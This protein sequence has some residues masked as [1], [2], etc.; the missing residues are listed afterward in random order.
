MAAVEYKL[1]S[2]EE[3]MRRARL[4]LLDAQPSTPTT[5]AAI[6]SDFGRWTPLANS[7]GFAFKSEY[8]LSDFLCYEDGEFIQFAYQ[9]ILL[10]EPD[11]QAQ[12]Y[13]LALRS[14]ELSKVE[15]V[16][17][18]RFSAEGMSHQVHI[19]GLL[20]PYK[21]QGW[22]R[23]P[24]IGG[25]I[26][27]A[28]SILRLPRLLLHKE[29]QIGRLAQRLQE[30]SGTTSLGIRDH[31]LRLSSLEQ[32]FEGQPTS[33]MFAA[34]T[35]KLEDASRLALRAMD[36]RTGLKGA[37]ENLQALV[38]D[39]RLRAEEASSREK[40]RYEIVSVALP[41]MEG[42]IEELRLR[43]EELISREQERRE[44]VSAVL[45]AEVPGLD[46]FY[47]KYEQQF[48]GEPEEI[49]VRL[50]PY[51]KVVSDLGLDKS[52]IPVLDLGCGRGEWLEMLREMGVRA[53]GVD[54]NAV[55]VSDCQEKGLSVSHGD[56]LEKLRSLE[57]QSIGLVTMMHLAEHLEFEDLIRMIDESYR[58]LA[59]GG[60]FIIET[61]NPENGMVAQL[62]FYMDPTHRNPL[63]PQMLSWMV[64]ARGF[65]QSDILPLYHGRP[66]TGLP[67]VGSDMPAF[68][69][70]NALANPTRASLDYAIVARK[71]VAA[72]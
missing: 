13:L 36:E 2:A 35:V 48:R 12:S 68:D 60:G 19:D 66:D 57:S 46:E 45:P 16:G 33:E 70:I 7:V 14:G 28:V 64:R 67:I 6:A 31:A 26:S 53:D 4:R 72:S 18:M 58:V 61:P 44:V 41:D 23:L 11:A 5:L 32:A 15:I 38:E 27:L 50:E 20:L 62:G 39:L 43:T 29:K 22:R 8:V 42:R 17:K 10:R 65:A 51:V 9:A 63:P 52:Q 71:G 37:I 54:M 30:V 25:A 34:L 49:K 47:A 55:L 69:V 3:V 40:E 24:L 1:V 59:P 56:A 21:I